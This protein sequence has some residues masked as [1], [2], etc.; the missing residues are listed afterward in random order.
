MIVIT[1][2]VHRSPLSMLVEIFYISRT[3]N[4]FI[5]YPPHS[6]ATYLVYRTCILGHVNVIQEI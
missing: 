3:E 2:R 4:S 5:L 6:T 1:V